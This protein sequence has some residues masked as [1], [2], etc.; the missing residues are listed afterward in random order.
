M[1]DRVRVDHGGGTSVQPAMRSLVGLISAIAVTALGA[2][3][4]APLR[5]QVR[6]VEHEPYPSAAA[7][8]ARQLLGVPDESS[9]H[10]GRQCEATKTIRV[11]DARGTPVPGAAVVLEHGFGG[12][13]MF[14]EPTPSYVDTTAP[15]LTDNA[16]EA[17]VCDP[18]TLQGSLRILDAFRALMNAGSS[19]TLRV[20]VGGRMRVLN[21]TFHWPLT[22][23]LLD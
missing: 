18:E 19:G 6:E 16:G 15:V 17:L 4:V 8:G 5:V 1:N 22:V 14:G 9:V 10:V 12:F 3:C 21:G 7:V 11:L 23:E 20:T 13:F 2:G